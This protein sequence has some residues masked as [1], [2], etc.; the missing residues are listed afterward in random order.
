MAIPVVTLVEAVACMAIGVGCGMQH[1]TAQNM[2]ALAV[3]VR[4]A[5]AAFS[6]PEI[7]GGAS[8]R[9]AK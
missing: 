9:T 8:R 7:V 1:G 4:L 5:I 6:R 3:V 2:R